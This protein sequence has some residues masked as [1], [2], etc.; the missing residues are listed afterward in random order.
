MRRPARVRL[1]GARRRRSESRDIAKLGLSRTFQHVRLLPQMSVIDNVAIGA[2]RREYPGLVVGV[3]AG[4]WRLDRRDESQ[5][6]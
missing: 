1:R 6:C 2:H 3:V 4:A 5:A